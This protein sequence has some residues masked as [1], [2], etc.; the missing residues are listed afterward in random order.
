MDVVESSW[1]TIIIYGQ[2][3]VLIYFL[4][5][6]KFNTKILLYLFALMNLYPW[7]GKTKFRV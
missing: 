3:K 7:S 2:Y 4:I 6:K 1:I 5:I